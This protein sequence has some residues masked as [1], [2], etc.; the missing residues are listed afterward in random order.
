MLKNFKDKTD[1]NLNI[2]MLLLAANIGI[3]AVLLLSDIAY[4]QNNFNALHQSNAYNLS[5][6]V[7][8]VALVVK[9][10]NGNK[11]NSDK[12]DI[13]FCPV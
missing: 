12:Q 9:N 7:L 13:C 11:D 6:M 1:N 3:P 8:D 5:I 4:D 10:M 2:C